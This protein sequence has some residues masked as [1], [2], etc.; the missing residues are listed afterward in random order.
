MLR[1]FNATLT[2][3]PMTGRINCATSLPF[4]S[5][6]AMERKDLIRDVL[7]AAGQFNDRQLWKRFT[8]SDCIGVRIPAEN[9]TL[10]AVV[11]G[12]GGQEYGLTLFRGSGGT[13]YVAAL[14]APEDPGDDALPDAD[15]LG[16]SMDRFDHLPAEGQELLREAGKHPRHDES[17]P[18][19]IAKP[20]GRR[21]RLPQDSELELLL[22]V[23]RGFMEAD[24]R[25]LLK[26]ARLDDEC[27]ICIL[28]LGGP[29]EAPEVSVTRA[30]WPRPEV[31]YHFPTE[32]AD[33]RAL[34][35][36][37][38]T[39]L[40]G[41][42]PMPAGV[43]GDDREPRLLLVAEDGDPKGDEGGRVLQ[44]LVVMP[45]Q[46]DQAIQGMVDIFRGRGPHREEGLPREIRFS[47][48]MLCSAM[49][50]I[51]SPLGIN[52]VY[53]PHLPVLH[54]YAA[55]FFARIDDQ[56]A[57]DAKKRCAAGARNIPVPAPDDLAGWKE[58][59]RE[60]GGRFAD[61]LAKNALW[62]SR[63]A[64]WY[65][66][67]EDIR[68]FFEKHQEQAVMQA[69]A[70]WVVLHYRATKSSQTHAEKLL[71]RGL[72]EGQAILLRARIASYPS[73]YRV[74]RHDPK[75]GTLD[76]E[77]VLLGGTVTVH[78]RMM[79]ENIADNLFFAARVFTAG[80][81]H[82]L[83]PAGPPLGMAM[84]TEAVEFLQKAHL[85]FTPAGLRRDAHKF[86]WL[87]DWS[88]QWESRMKSMRLTNMDGDDLL[89]HT[90]S[91]SVAD[92]AETR[93]ALLA[94]KDIEQEEGDE[95]VWN[96]ETGHA[97][98]T[99]GGPVLLGR[100]ELLGEEL[101]LTVNSAQRLAR[102]RQWIEKLPGVVFRNV[103]TR[104]WNEAE[105]DRPLDER[106]AKEEEG[107]AVEITPDLATAI[108]R[109]MDQKYMAWVDTA[110]P[111]LKGQSPRQACQT[112]AG[113]QQVA[114]LIRTM[115][116]PMG[117]SPVHVPRQA[118]LQA[119]GLEGQAT[120]TAPLAR[121]PLPAP[122]VPSRPTFSGGKVGRNDPC[123]CGSGK[124]YK[125]CC[126]R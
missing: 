4:E 10:L 36:L 9:D 2:L 62:S 63:A 31:S 64:K 109:M 74:A 44:A 26:P 22:R 116:D 108:Q 114:M 88:D 93:R 34:P 115:P 47:S 13:A 58:A 69:Y 78:D 105:K 42:L 45:D 19:L 33:L 21:P 107:G 38:A 37:E 84:G 123:P 52:C 92:P 79:S 104:P 57:A 30:P 122:A 1:R 90:A 117:P 91:F 86:G 81:F 102:A 80:Q 7:Q 46:F 110:L 49:T 82:F 8:N 99:M 125:K 35:Q 89:W 20:P 124:K 97:A 53:Q 73:L 111:V 14:I 66:G 59:D 95:F 75:A 70:G 12:E 40:A 51:L 94:R 11:M 27:G 112:P 72:P 103:T 56:L 83:D 65:F 68:H 100:I 15:L 98:K 50:G 118:M 6:S 54:A 119:L 87:W 55:D 41:W 32:A 16:F 28:T 126:G 61:Y 25:Q 24:Q 77:D 29:P 101:V 60:V 120:S 67:D 3:P 48:R 106:I 23:L 76:L 85:E 113:R 5:E 71:A 43:E 96:Q 39:W 17:V 18:S 121:P